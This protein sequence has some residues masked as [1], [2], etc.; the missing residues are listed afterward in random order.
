MSYIGKKPTDVP[1]EASDINSTI[2]TGQV[3]EAS[4]ADDVVFAMSHSK[5]MI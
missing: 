2:I 3:A 5:I 1:I 4:I